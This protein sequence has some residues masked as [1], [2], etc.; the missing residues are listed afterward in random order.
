MHIKVDRSEK[1]SIY[2]SHVSIILFFTFLF[3]VLLSSNVLSVEDFTAYTANPDDIS[4]D[5]CQCSPR[6]LE[7]KIKNIGYLDHSYN[8]HFE[9]TAKNF[10]QPSKSSISVGSGQEKVFYALVG[11][12]CNEKGTYV[13]DTMIIDDQGLAKKI[14][15]TMNIKRCINI[16]VVPINQ[17][18][19]TSSCKALVYEYKIKNTGDFQETYDI[20]IKPESRKIKKFISTNK[21]SFV[22]KPKTEESLLVYFTPD[23]NYFGHTMNK[24]IIY[25]DNT[26]LKATTYFEI[27]V[28]PKFDF[29]ANIDEEFNLCEQKDYIKNIYIKNQEDKAQKFLLSIQEPS[30]A[31]LSA[32]SITLG[33]DT[34]YD[35]NFT[36]SPG[37]DSKGDY[38]LLLKIKLEDGPALKTLSSN[39]T[40]N[41]CYDFDITLP[42]SPKACNKEQSKIPITIINNAETDEEFELEFESDDEKYNS[43]KFE[44]ETITVTKDSENNAFL[45]ITPDDDIFVRGTIIARP[46]SNPDLE[47]EKTI[48]IRTVSEDKC[49]E[50]ITLEDEFVLPK[51]DSRKSIELTLKNTG[52]LKTD[53]DLA[54]EDTEQ[55]FSLD[56][57]KL[58]LEPG[59]ESSINL[60]YDIPE[61][62]SKIRFEALLLAS[63]STENYT[64]SSKLILR[65]QTTFSDLFKYNNLRILGI[66]II[67][68]LLVIIA[69]IIYIQKTEGAFKSKKKKDKKTK[70][71]VKKKGV[72]HKAEK[73]VKKKKKKKKKK[74]KKFFDVDLKFSDKHLEK[75]YVFDFDRKPKKTTSFWKYFWIIICILVIILLII[76]AYYYMPTIKTKVSTSFNITLG[77]KLNNKLL[78]AFNFSSLIQP[79][80]IITDQQEPDQTDTQDFVEEIDEEEKIKDDEVEEDKDDEEEM[81]ED[82]EEPEKV[83]EEHTDIGKEIMQEFE[84][85]RQELD[86]PNKTIEPKFDPLLIKSTIL[87]Y[88]S[89][90]LYYFYYLIFAILILFILI[91][92][93]NR[94]KKGGE[95]KKP[96]KKAKKHKVKVK[97]KKVKASKT[98]RKAKSKKTRP[99]SKK[100][101][102]VSQESKTKFWK[103]L[104]WILLIM[105]IAFLI[106]YYINMIREYLYYVLIGVIILIIL[107]IIDKKR[108]KQDNNTNKKSTNKKK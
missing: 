66:L 61:N 104:L 82:E 16:D 23:C 71:K 80:D 93:I 77:D 37:K 92:V 55:L 19:T 7:F 28:L 29:L 44:Q 98:I 47:I 88:G 14:T 101:K 85:K 100:D 103:I 4:F 50:I 91:L 53:Y 18:Q 31:D 32:K 102:K 2:V 42:D 21:K 70:E 89:S 10:V 49:Y 52:V 5:L 94:L 96:E 75:G 41:E 34:E 81:D 56:I 63:V 97:T 6:I 83:E 58:T 22:L 38:P 57:D 1:K 15:H 65:K 108:Q 43:T 12:P 72:K 11:A 69:F 51:N 46:K 78:S 3:I 84:R 9:N 17:N 13:L 73:K 87:S 106:V 76:G 107:I 8:I 48:L 25:T 20:K 90:Y 30:F 39:I 33:P 60:N 74:P 24:L 45:L 27:N 68:I 59:E 62:I 26:D 79:I 36:L 67:F 95:N 99:K 105:V 64:Y 40:V 86:K 35:L 54:I